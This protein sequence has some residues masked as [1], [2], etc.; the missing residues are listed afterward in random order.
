MCGIVGC[1]GT[2]PSVAEARRML[3]ALRHRGP[4]DEGI[5]VGAGAVLGHRRLSIIDLDGGKQPIANEDQSAWIVCNGE[6]YNYKELRRELEQA[7]H[8]FATLSDTEVIL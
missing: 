3:D 8:R 7:G 6:I 4:D 1:I 5:Y 2:A